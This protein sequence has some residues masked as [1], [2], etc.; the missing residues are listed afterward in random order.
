MPQHRGVDLG[1]REVDPGVRSVATRLR[2]HLGAGDVELPV[3]GDV[4]DD[5]ARRRRGAPD[6]RLDLVAHAAALA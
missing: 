4:E 3:D 1:E 6:E 2:Q 5:R